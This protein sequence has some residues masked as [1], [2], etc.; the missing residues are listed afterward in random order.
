MREKHIFSLTSSSIWT[1]VLRYTVHLRFPLL[2]KTVEVK[3]SLMFR[4]LK[5]Y[6]CNMEQQHFCPVPVS[7]YTVLSGTIFYRR[8]NL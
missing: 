2:L 1:R 3:G 6:I 4:A 8:N 7:L 5:H